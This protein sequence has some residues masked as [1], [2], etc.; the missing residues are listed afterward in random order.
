MPISSNNINIDTPTS[1][2]NDNSLYILTKKFLNLIQKSPE[3]TVDLK[4]ASQILGVSKRR[5]Y[6]ITNVLEG[7]DLL[8]KYGVNTARWKGGEICNYLQ[9]NFE[10]ESTENENLKIHS[11]I[12][13]DKENTNRLSY[14]Q[15]KKLENNEDKKNEELLLLQ[16]EEFFLDKKLE[17]LISAFEEMSKCQRNLSN[18]FVTYKDIDS[19]PVLKNKLIFAVKTPKD[20]TFDIPYLEN[21]NHIL[22]LTTHEGGIN[23]YYVSD[24]NN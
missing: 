23:V 4:Q 24:E 21:N 3:G 7:L 15:R 19:I 17:S 14:Y 13:F 10:Q 6:D 2:R 22:N 16:N 5:I 9:S 12:S 20:T 1:S 8:C 11:D 18:A